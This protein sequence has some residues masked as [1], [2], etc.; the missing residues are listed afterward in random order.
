MFMA[1]LFLYL[2]LEHDIMFFF[3]LSIELMG[4]TCVA[5]GR[6]DVPYVRA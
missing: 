4:H 1:S 3:V 6:V 5:A 2:Y